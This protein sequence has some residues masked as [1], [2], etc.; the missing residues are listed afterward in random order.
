MRAIDLFI[1]WIAE[2]KIS[3]NIYITKEL[4][5]ELDYFTHRDLILE[6]LEK[7]KPYEL[8]ETIG[9]L[10]ELLEKEKVVQRSDE[11]EESF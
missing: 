6:E 1:D 3:E 2:Q 10:E 4:L 11:V 8:E 9:I 7:F 5:K